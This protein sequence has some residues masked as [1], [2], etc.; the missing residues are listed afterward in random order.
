MNVTLKK[1]VIDQTDNPAA[2]DMSTQSTSTV[3]HVEVG[4]PNRIRMWCTGI[5]AMATVKIESRQSGEGSSVKWD[6]GFV[7][8]LETALMVSLYGNKLLIWNQD[9]EPCYDSYDNVIVPW[10]N[11]NSVVKDAQ[12]GNTYNLSMSDYPTMDMNTHEGTD[13]LKRARKK[14]TFNTYLMLQRNELGKKP[15]RSYVRSFGWST[16]TEVAV[17]ENKWPQHMYNETG[18]SVRTKSRSV[19]TI[20]SEIAGQFR[21]LPDTALS[22]NGSIS[23]KNRPS[24]F[25]SEFCSLSE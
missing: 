20:G 5:T 12:V 16:E 24:S 21:D 22:A 25:W 11:E 19:S 7:Q 18:Y 9:A 17:Q 3:S 1:W 10:Y 6:I 4:Y 2:I 13:P 15:K 8:I 14:L 23:T